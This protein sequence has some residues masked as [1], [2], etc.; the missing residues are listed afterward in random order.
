MASPSPLPIPLCHANDTPLD[1]GTTDY[2]ISCIFGMLIEPE[3][4]R[5]SPDFI[6]YQDTEESPVAGGDGQVEEG[7]NR[8]SSV[9]DQVP[10]HIPPTSDIAEVRCD[11]DD[12][13]SLNLPSEY[14]HDEYDRQFHFVPEGHAHQ[15]HAEVAREAAVATTWEA[16][17]TPLT[18]YVVTDTDDRDS[19]KENHDPNQEDNKNAE[20]VSRDSQDAQRMGPRCR[21]RGGR[22]SR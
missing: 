12:H 9:T 14:H 4:G 17:Y 8:A 11:P 15:V 1:A 5:V 21:G 7:A 20:K 22:K 10:V 13:L 6:E 3:R 2:P 18:L 19:D 16:E